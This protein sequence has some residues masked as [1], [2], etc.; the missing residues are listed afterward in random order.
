M[1][2]RVQLG[3]D[4]RGKE[5]AGVGKVW[6]SLYDRMLSTDGLRRA[7]KK[8]KAAKGA[9]GV[10]GQSIK[11][12]AERED[13]HLDQLE[14]ELRNKTYEAQPVRRV[15]IPKDGGGER[16]LGIPAVRDRV[17]Q[18]RLLDILQ[19]IF[20]PEFHPSSYAYRPGRS[21]HQA[22]AKVSV[23]VRR[24]NLKWVVDMDLSKCFD[25][26]S[27][28]L[29]IEVCRKRVRDGSILSLIGKFL[30]SG[31]MEGGVLQ[32]SSVGSPQGGVISPLLANI[33]LNEFDQEMR[34]RGQR[35][36]RYADDTVILCRSRA[37]AENALIRAKEILEG[38][39]R[40][41]VNR[42]KTKI[43]HSRE[44]IPYLGVVICDAYTR[45]QDKKVKRFKQK[46]KELTR[47]NGRGNLAE[48]IQSLNPVLRGFANYFRVANC[49]GILANLMGWIRRRL[50]AR[51]L[52]MWKRPNRLHRKLRQLGHSGAFKRI[53]MRSWRNSAS[54]L[55]SLALPNRELEKLGLVDISKIE[56][57]YL[58]QFI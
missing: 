51:Q 8:V 35:I 5:D 6:Y 33:Y 22:I 56:T 45:I 52:A 39:L 10:D 17:V 25:T 27:H 54:P 44:G 28:N 7:F 16:A 36:V 11:A 42:E 46:V 53:K 32:E 12:F 30:K 37:A 19:P 55:V 13:E 24:Y 18:Q 2:E 31:V 15:Y 57:G 47:R 58:P 49:K 34:R 1:A 48:V 14:E 3:R 26:L 20:E 21:C 50:R 41:K 9:A 4:N 43:V 40:L 23:L 29:I 38:S